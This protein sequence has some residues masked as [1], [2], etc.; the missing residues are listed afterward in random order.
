MKSSIRIA[1]AAAFALA[2]AAIAAGPVAASPLPHPGGHVFVQSDNLSGNTVVAYDRAPDGSLTQAGVYA[3]G[4]KG[5][6]LDGSVVDH[7]ASE[8]SLAYDSGTLIAV[9]AGSNTVTDFAVVGDHLLRRQVLSSGGTFPVSV[10]VHG[11]RVFVLNAR[12]GG[13]VQGYLEVA[14]ILIRVPAWHRT[15]GLAA[16]SPEFTSAPGQIAFSPDGSKLLV[17]TKNGGNSIEVFASDAI[18]G[19]SSTP[20]VTSLP[21]AVPFGLAFDAFG[22]LAVAEAGPSA[23]GTFSINRDGSLQSIATAPTAQAATC[24]IVASGSVL[25]SSNAGSGSV[26]ALVDS[27]GG[28]IGVPVNATTNKG[29]VDAA[30]SAD[31]RFVYVQTGAAGTVDA[32]RIGSSG[33]LTLVGSVVVPGAVGGEGIVAI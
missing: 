25:Y 17:T 7:L 11:S 32:F 27:A 16:P 31:Q 2:A 30:V 26:S 19:I 10:A 9:N 24:W 13:S 6:A 33:S 5:G 28:S 4:G 23:V 15:L 14:G 12:D 1:V 18:R 20:T 8:G 21:G 3:T 22:H 29:T